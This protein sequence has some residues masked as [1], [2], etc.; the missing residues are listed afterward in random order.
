MIIGSGLLAQAFSRALK[1]HD[2]ICVY[3]AGVSNSACTDLREFQRER[4]RLTKA[5]EEKF[6]SEVFVYFGTC[7]VEDSNVLITPY[8]QHKI[9]MEKIVQLHSNYLILRLPQVA[10]RTPNPHTLL[11][12]LYN[13][14]S[15]SERFSLWADA[16]RNIIDV[17]DVVSIAKNL[18]SEKSVYGQS[19]NVANINSYSLMHIVEQMSLVI[20]KPAFYDVMHNGSSYDINVN[21]IFKYINKAGIDFGDN[22]LHKTLKKYYSST[23]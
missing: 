4:D 21:S 13:R 3:A 20:K 19:F 12:Y 7:S 17:E 1:H 11:N 6:Y 5:L 8:V 14:I 10:G 22:Y 15:R 16:R 2:S 18:I 9:A 23:E